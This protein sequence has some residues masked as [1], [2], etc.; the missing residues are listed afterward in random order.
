MILAKRAASGTPALAETRVNKSVSVSL[1]ADKNACVSR[2]LKPSQYTAPSGAGKRAKRRSS[3]RE[4]SDP[5]A[6]DS[7]GTCPV[8]LFCTRVLRSLTKSPDS[9]FNN[10]AANAMRVCRS[11]AAPVTEVCGTKS[12]VCDGTALT[13]NCTEKFSL[14]VLKNAEVTSPT[15]DASHAVF[16]LIKTMPRSLSAETSRA[17]VS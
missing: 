8:T 15:P 12:T 17:C 5:T 14:S 10:G 13:K 3:S 6:S 7:S 9:S 4:A 16:T 2:T 1:S 11:S